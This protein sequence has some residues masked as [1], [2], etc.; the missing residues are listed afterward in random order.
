MPSTGG[1]KKAFKQTS[2]PY[3]RPKPIPT[4]SSLPAI[5]Q[6]NTQHDTAKYQQQ[7]AYSP[8]NL[9]HNEK[10][11]SKSFSDSTRSQS[12]GANDLSITSSGPNRAS[13]AI[14][15]I[16]PVLPKP[17]SNMPYVS[18][19]VTVTTAPAIVAPFREESESNDTTHYTVERKRAGMSWNDNTLL[20][21][22]P[23]HFRLFVGNLSG[24]VTDDMLSRAFKTGN[25]FP[26]LQKVKV[27]RDK[28]PPFKAKGYGFV[29]FSDPDD[30]FRAFKEMNGKYVGNHPIQLRKAVT[31]IKPVEMQKRAGKKMHGHKNGKNS[32]PNLAAALIAS[33]KIKTTNLKKNKPK[34][35]S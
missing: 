3:S 21:W 23:S 16:G 5:P 24:E 31:E 28:K 9:S 4:P 27:I 18:P 34:P 35:S 15:P 20:E 8:N 17:A 6:T 32:E 12:I 22:D 30:Y 26:S 33:T 19:A 10:N 11:K 1:W 29:S 2:H 13:P 14:G 25:R 7:E